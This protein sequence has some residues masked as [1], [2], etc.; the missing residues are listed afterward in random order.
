VSIR[1]VN[2]LRKSA[3]YVDPEP[4]SVKD[5]PAAWSLSID[6]LLGIPNLLPFAAVIKAMDDARSVA[7]KCPDDPRLYDHVHGPDLR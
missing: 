5:D 6:V 1:Q 3:F 7:Q 2:R 4:F